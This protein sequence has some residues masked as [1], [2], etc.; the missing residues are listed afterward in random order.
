MLESSGNNLVPRIVKNPQAYNPIGCTK[1]WA[2]VRMHEIEDM[3]YDYYDP[4]S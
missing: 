4:W 2:I 3:E 1:F